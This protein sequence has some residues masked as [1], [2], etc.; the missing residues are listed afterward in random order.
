MSVARLRT[1]VLRTDPTEAPRGIL[2]RVHRAWPV[3][4][5]RGRRQTFPAH[6]K[7]KPNRGALVP[8]VVC[9][10]RKASR[11]PRTPESYTALQQRPKAPSAI[12]KRLVVSYESGFS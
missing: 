12:V 6:P 3:D 5:R 1:A 10:Q 9:R 7:A 11:R 8:T 4:L 2:E